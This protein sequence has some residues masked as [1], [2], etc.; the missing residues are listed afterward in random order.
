M[1]NL[2]NLELSRITKWL[3][4]NN[5]IVNVSKAVALPISTVSRGSLNPKSEL[6]FVLNG[7]NLYPSYSAKY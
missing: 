6:T 4:A 3:L 1:K 7:Q 2:A 5:L